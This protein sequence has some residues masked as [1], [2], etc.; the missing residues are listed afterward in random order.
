MNAEPHADTPHD[1]AD[2]L[3]TNERYKRYL[4]A[5]PQA[6]RA[7]VLTNNIAD[8][9]DRQFRAVENWAGAE[10]AGA[11]AQITQAAALLR[12]AAATMGALPED[13]RPRAGR[14]VAGVGAS[15]GVALREGDLVRVGDS[16]LEDY[17][18]VV[19]VT[20]LRVVEQR[21][22][23]VMVTGPDGTRTWLPRGHVTICPT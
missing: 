8:R 18:G 15:A 1:P 21:G 10:M 17:E 22:N 6:R 13:Y 16:H 7:S 9:C 20:G 14:R 11:R 3:T 2:D 4:R 23:R 5:L 19:D 12:A